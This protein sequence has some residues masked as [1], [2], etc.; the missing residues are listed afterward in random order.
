MTAQ[1]KSNQP[2]WT[3]DTNKLI[4]LMLHSYDFNDSFKQLLW[5]WM[6]HHISIETLSNSIGNTLSLFKYKP[7]HPEIIILPL[8]SFQPVKGSVSAPCFRRYR[9]SYKYL[10]WVRLGVYFRCPLIHTNEFCGLLEIGKYIGTHSEDTLHRG[11]SSRKRWL[12]SFFELE[13]HR[14]FERW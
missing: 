12:C 13:S 1:S 8:F 10:Q 3:V 11:G 6:P 2:N 7:L 9:T 4:E 14:H 5:H